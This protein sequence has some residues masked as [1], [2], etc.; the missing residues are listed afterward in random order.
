MGQSESHPYSNSANVAHLIEND[1]WQL[2]IQQRQ[3]QEL[4]DIDLNCSVVS[5]PFKHKYI[6]KFDYQIPTNCIMALLFPNHP[7]EKRRVLWTS[8]R[9]ED[10]QREINE[11]IRQSSRDGLQLVVTS[12]DKF[13]RFYNILGTV[14]LVWAE[15]INQQTLN[16]QENTIKEGVP[17]LIEM[18]G[19]HCYRNIYVFGNEQLTKLQDVQTIEPFHYNIFCCETDRRKDSVHLVPTMSNS[20]AD[21]ITKD[22]VVR[23]LVRMDQEPPP[24]STTED[25]E[26]TL[27]P[28]TGKFVNY[29]IQNPD[30]LDEEDK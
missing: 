3:G 27:V 8:G 15:R 20:Q 7:I 6:I 18:N 16:N 22:P 19:Q 5:N 17:M 9:L 30:E 10:L 23:T 21:Q 24:F 1:Q 28:E 4:Q 29:E 2:T 26:L 12:G 25:N 11:R 14:Y 13:Y